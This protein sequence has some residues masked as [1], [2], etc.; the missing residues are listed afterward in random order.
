MPL[1]ITGDEEMISSFHAAYAHAAQAAAGARAAAEAT[2]RAL[3]D[4]A[5]ELGALVHPLGDRENPLGLGV[6]FI[7][8]SPP[9]L[10]APTGVHLEEAPKER[11]PSFA[12]VVL[13]T[14]DLWFE[15]RSDPSTGF[16]ALTNISA[17][18]AYATRICGVAV[19]AN[20]HPHLVARISDDGRLDL[21]AVNDAA[22]LLDV[23][24]VVVANTY[25]ERTTTLDRS[26]V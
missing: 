7:R 5:G 18:E 14:P 19:D 8:R 20:M 22:Q 25:E 10:D 15:L 16:Q 23:F 26:A 4:F 24:L 9:H 11:A 12:A 6:R 3:F 2:H 1:M 13:E 21:P 17:M